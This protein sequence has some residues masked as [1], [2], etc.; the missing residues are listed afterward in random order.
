MDSAEFTDWI[1]YDSLDPFGEVRGDLR[2]GILLSHYYNSQG[3]EQECRPR[4]F[5]PFIEAEAPAEE[6]SIEDQINVMLAVGAYQK[7]LENS[8]GK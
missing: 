4:D 8:N 5:M 7:G 1:A 6:Q 3:A 2:M